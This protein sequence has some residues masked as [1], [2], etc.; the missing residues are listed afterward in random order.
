[1]GAGGLAALTT[2]VNRDRANGDEPSRLNASRVNPSP[3][4][5][6][7]Q[8]QDVAPPA[9][10]EA[11]PD[12]AA[13]L[14]SDLL[15]EG[16][17]AKFLRYVRIDTRS[18]PDGADVP[19][20]P[21]QLDLSRLLARELEAVGLDDV[22]V[23][24]HGIVTATLPAT[25]GFEGAPT[26]GLLA[27]V[28]TSPA[29]SG[30]NVNPIVHRA[31]AGGPIR[32]PSG[33]AVELGPHI[34]PRVRGHDI[35]T[36][37]GSTLLGADDKAGVAEIMEALCRFRRAAA[38]PGAAAA[39]QGPE[40]APIRPAATPHPRIRVAFTTDE[41]TGRGIDFLDIA[42]FGAH[43]AYTLDGS[44]AGEI[45]AENFNAENLRIRIEGRSA[46]PGMARGQLIN[47][48]HLA[49]LLVAQLPAAERPETTC[50]REGFYHVDEIRGNVEAVE[51]TLL[52]RDF[53]REGLARRRACVEAL[54]AALERSHPGARATARVTGGYENMAPHLAR[55]PEVV[56]RAL[57]AARAAGLEP[58]LHAI[59]GGT[60]GARLTARGLP[61]PNLFTGAANFHSR[62]EWV[63]VQWM[64]QA[65][66]VVVEL[67]RRWALDL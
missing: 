67:A 14:L 37:D 4:A 39:P 29:V 25:P 10:A 38:T 60:D 51:L 3:S 66:A 20:T 63:S 49:A 27:H 46:H 19:T 22:D 1:M 45:E 34:E 18:D 64:E 54:L 32:L 53:D 31:Y 30:R 42:R 33:P 12:V 58:S 24:A 41:E 26:I 8:N 40:P 56:R 47:A 36:S 59:R 65:V 21:G 17:L 23:D 43:V 15:H 62:A 28:D 52:L 57:E 55:H 11:A 48:V 6:A 35:V 13:D 9:P 16:V 50:G 61:T 2:H 5:E 44:L 7:A